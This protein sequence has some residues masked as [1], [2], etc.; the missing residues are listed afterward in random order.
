MS[1]KKK[2]KKE[3]NFK[4]RREHDNQLNIFVLFFGA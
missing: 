3:K 2:E 4:R 1:D